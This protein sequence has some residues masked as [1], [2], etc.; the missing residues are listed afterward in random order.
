MDAQVHS[1]LKSINSQNISGQTNHV[2][3]YILMSKSSQGCNEDVEI[4][5]V[6]NS[7][8]HHW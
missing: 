2:D 5:L 1:P 6:E 7:K 3:K 8:E 4:L